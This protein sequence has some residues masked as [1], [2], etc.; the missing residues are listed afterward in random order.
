MRVV[1]RNKIRAKMQIR[2]VMLLCLLSAYGGCARV[3]PTLEL[4]ADE[5]V[6]SFVNA[7]LESETDV[8]RV[9]DNAV[10]S[11]QAILFVNLD[12]AIMQP[13]RKQFAEFMIEYQRRH[14]ANSLMFHYVDCTQITSGYS[15]LR[16]LPGWQELETNGQSLIHGWG[17]LVWMERGHVLHV[18]PILNFE[19]VSDLVRKTEQIMS[20]ATADNKA[21]NGRRR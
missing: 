15:P 11:E 2:T 14:P 3:E 21:V 1:I 7:R 17:E 8:Q 12:W 19:T 18:E 10:A 20:L 16:S 4:T 13:Q 6:A 5:I 9:I